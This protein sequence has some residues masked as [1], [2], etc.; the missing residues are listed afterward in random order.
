MHRA[1]ACNLVL[2][3]SVFRDF[4]N[5]GVNSPA[6]YMSPAVALTGRTLTLPM[7]A[8]EPQH[9]FCKE[10]LYPALAELSRLPL[11]SEWR[12][13][14]ELTHYGEEQVKEALERGVAWKEQ[15]DAAKAAY[16][17][18]PLPRRRHGQP[19]NRPHRPSH[20]R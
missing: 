3:D 8:D 20:A 11:W 9:T 15:R 5:K 18:V 7:E 4:I 13:Q 12:R 14:L 19:P 6:E 1:P 10:Q 17:L 2:H 16:D